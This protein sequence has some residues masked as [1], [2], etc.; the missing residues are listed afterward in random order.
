MKSL[1]EALKDGRLVELPQG[2]TKDQA[3]EFLAHLIEAIPDIGTKDDLMKGV[4]EREAAA[5]TG[6]GRGVACPHCRVRTEGEL[7]C[8]AGWSPGGIDYG[9]ADGK[10][11]HLLVMYYVPDSER[12]AYLKEVSGLATA[13]SSG[14]GIEDI[15]GLPDIH[16]VRER[17]LDWV[18]LAI[19]EAIP[20]TK[21][22]MIKLE[23]RQAV[24]A[25]ALAADARILGLRVVT[26]P[27][28]CLVL[29]RDG[30][31]SESLEKVADLG[32]RLS[33]SGAV[34]GMREFDVGG[35]RLAILSEALFERGRREYEAVAIEI[36]A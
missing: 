29:C 27:E 7:R 8:A 26:W 32:L 28:G 12:N 36:K 5:N 6:I 13:I 4:S 25:A 33:G 21:A 19:T 24:V 1:L 14:K 34:Q 3:L 20:E 31:L 30:P 2:Y 16:G 17:L 11:V 23:A 9:S 10:P 18:G 15:E 22:R 35:Y